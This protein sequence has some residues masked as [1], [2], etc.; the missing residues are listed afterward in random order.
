MMMLMHQ[1]GQAAAG[2]FNPPPNVT[3][4]GGMDGPVVGPAMNQTGQ[5][6]FNYGANY[7][8]LPV[9]LIFICFRIFISHLID[10]L[11]LLLYLQE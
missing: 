3:A 2:G 4:P 7:G 9:C 10:F 1:P 11:L 8:G 5:Q 6:G